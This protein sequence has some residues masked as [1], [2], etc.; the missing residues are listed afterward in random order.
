MQFISEF[1]V[2]YTDRKPVWKY[3]NS[4]FKL[5]QAIVFSFFISLNP[6]KK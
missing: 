4:S 3:E 6:P 1:A 2:A 5:W